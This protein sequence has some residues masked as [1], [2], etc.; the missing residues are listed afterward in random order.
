MLIKSVLSLVMSSQS[1]LIIFSYPP[2]IRVQDILLE[3]HVWTEIEGVPVC[4]GVPPWN[5]VHDLL[6]DRGTKTFAGIVYPVAAEEHAAVAAIC[7][8]LPKDVVRYCISPVSAAAL[9][10]NFET[11]LSTDLDIAG[12]LNV[13]VK[14]FPEVLRPYRQILRS[15]LRGELDRD[16]LPSDLLRVAGSYFEEN[17]AAAHLD[18]WATGG[19]NVNRVEITWVYSPVDPNLPGY[20]PS[21][22]EIELAQYFAEDIWFYRENQVY[23]IGINHLDTT[24]TDYGLRLPNDLLIN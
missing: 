4:A 8:L 19:A 23:A 24:L 10:R 14:Q 22:L 3:D 11:E 13:S 16:Q 9:L 2:Q 18:D 5:P 6:V 1:L 20:F 7:G 15:C 12:D 21:D 17:A